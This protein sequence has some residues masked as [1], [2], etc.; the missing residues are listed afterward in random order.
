MGRMRDFLYAT[1]IT[2]FLIIPSGAYAALVNINT[3]DATL[4]DTLPGIGPTKAKAI[5]DYRMSNGP[6]RNL[7]DIQKVSGIGSSIYSE[8]LPF[9]TLDADATPSLSV[10]VTDTATTSVTQ[11]GA[12]SYV[13]PPSL[14]M[15]SVSGDED[16]FLRVPLRLHA[17]VTTK[18]GAIDNSAHIV[19]SFGDGSMAEGTDVEKEYLFSGTYLIV[20]TATDGSATARK[21]SVITATPAHVRLVF[22]PGGEVGIANDADSRL[23]ISDW[24]VSAGDATFRIPLDTIILPKGH[25]FFASTLTNLPMH[26]DTKLLYPD[27]ALATQSSF[28]QTT[29][30]NEQPSVASGSYKQ[31]ETVE[32][33]NNP[34]AQ[35]QFHDEAV[36][37]PAAT[38]DEGVAAGAV[39]PIINS[40]SSQMAA[41]ATTNAGPL[42]SRWT[43]GLLGVVV[44]AGGAFILL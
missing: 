13:P 32:T 1:I 21:E 27:G 30:S 22:A 25:V 18:A 5:V 7:S 26:T 4:L 10:G 35:S 41:V 40:S 9:I 14:L 42:H 31:V 20:V 38:P 6:F 15:I 23:D 29:I 44:L 28:T 43:L 24:R 12:S 39:S 2:L 16:A 8:I 11:A 36:V 19:W 33:I 37:A 3:A 34:K 17:R